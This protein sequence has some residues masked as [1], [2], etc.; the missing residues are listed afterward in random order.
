MDYARRAKLREDNV[1]RRGILSRARKFIFDKGYAVASKFVVNLLGK[2][3]WVPTRVSAEI[4]TWNMLNDDCYAQNAFSDRLSRFDFDFH[5]MLVV[6][7]LHEVH[8]GIEKAVLTHLFR[9]I[10]SFTSSLTIV[11]KRYVELNLVC[12]LCTTEASRFRYRLV[13]TFGRDTIR[14]FAENMSAMKKLA[15]RDFEDMIQVDT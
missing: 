11:D 13:P 15:A 3:S 1:E 7:V 2:N 9:I 12:W 8:L 10:H 6:D 4:H 14:R 5:R